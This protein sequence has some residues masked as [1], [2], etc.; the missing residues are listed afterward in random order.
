[1]TRFYAR[2]QAG[3]AKSEALRAAQSDLMETEG[4][5]H[6]F[7]WAAFQLIGDWR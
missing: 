4:S 1:M 7:H 3:E 2:L 5:R 6:P